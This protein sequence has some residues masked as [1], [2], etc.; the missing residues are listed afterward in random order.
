MTS[1]DQAQPVSGDAVDTATAGID[2]GEARHRTVTWHDP[3]IP[4]QVATKL[5]GI[6]YMH[7]LADGRIPAPPIVGLMDARLTSVTPGAAEFTLTP[8][9]SHFNPIGAVHGGIICTLL[10]SAAG[11]AVHTTLPQ[12][13]G[14]TSVEIKVNFMRGTTLDSG[15]LIARGWVKKSGRRVAFA[16]A[17]ITDSLG[18]TV[19]TAST[20][21]LVFEVP[22]PAKG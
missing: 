9:E 19:A 17:E 4:A 16:E 15:D 20:S 7:A 11:C 10:D 12:G 8:N 14:Y 2:W 1:I 21:L 5:S 3:A 22:A 18:K 6:D 13:V